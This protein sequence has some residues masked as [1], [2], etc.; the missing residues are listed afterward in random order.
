MLAF[1][2]L[3]LNVLVGDVSSA[4]NSAKSIK[5]CTNVDEMVLSACF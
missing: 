2:D 4:S 5:F 3:G 1:Q